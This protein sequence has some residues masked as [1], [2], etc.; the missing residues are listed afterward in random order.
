AGGDLGKTS[1]GTAWP[2]ARQN[3]FSRVNYAFKNKYLLELVGR[4]DGSYIFPAS[5]RFG[6]FPAVSVGWRISEEPFFRD[7]VSLFDDLKLRASWGKTG[8]DR[9]D[10]WQY[11][12]A[13]GFGSGEVF[14][15]QQVKSV[16]QIRTPN[17]NVTWEVAT[18]RNVG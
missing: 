1:G 17:P 18:Q 14:G 10:P 8:N 11:V 13:Y 4:L 6:L 5:K 2:V 7:H 16:Y 15:G 12:A 3:Y 9:I